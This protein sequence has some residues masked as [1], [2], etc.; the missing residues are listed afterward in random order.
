VDVT[1]K[2]A[3]DR[4]RGA[5]LVVCAHPGTS[6]RT[7]P[8]RT[9]RMPEPAARKKFDLAAYYEMRKHYIWTSFVAVYPPLI[10]ARVLKLGI[11]C[12]RDSER[13]LEEKRQLLPSG[14]HSV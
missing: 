7:L 12:N 3:L 10:I 6:G 1:A 14:G 4:A 5:A 2:A 13:P 8:D 9:G 11:S